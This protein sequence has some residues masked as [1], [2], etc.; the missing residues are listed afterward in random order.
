MAHGGV[1]LECPRTLQSEVWVRSYGVLSG[2]LPGDI[3]QLCE[4]YG[5]GQ[6]TPKSDARES[7]SLGGMQLNEYLL[8]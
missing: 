3:A 8:K 6:H 2:V 4:C 5:E 7:R 1:I